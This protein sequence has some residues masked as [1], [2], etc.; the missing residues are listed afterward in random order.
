MTIKCPICGGDLT[1]VTC[2]RDSPATCVG[3]TYAC[4]TCG[5]TSESSAMLCL[6]IK[7]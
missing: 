6:S 4:V 1:D 5:R 3:R 2:L 7:R